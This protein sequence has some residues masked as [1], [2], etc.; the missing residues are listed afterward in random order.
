MKQF[1]DK[2][3]KARNTII[4]AAQTGTKEA[5]PTTATSHAS[6]RVHDHSDDNHQVMPS[7]ATNLSTCQL[8]DQKEF[9]HV[10]P[11]EYC[12]TCEIGMCY[13]CSHTHTENHHIV[14]WGFDIFN[15]M[16]APRNELNEKFNAGYRTLLDW[17][18]AKCPCGTK[19]VGNV[20]STVCSACGTATCSAECHDHFV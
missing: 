15:S 11:L 4:R 3:L 2:L 6:N 20:K 14:D 9:P 17:E 7:T 5:N 16:E 12:T 13:I 19:L 18:S 10:K 8:H 1:A